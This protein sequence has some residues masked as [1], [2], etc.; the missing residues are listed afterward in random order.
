MFLMFHLCFVF[1]V[2]YV[3]HNHRSLNFGAQFIRTSCCISSAQLRCLFLNQEPNMLK[4]L[5]PRRFHSTIFSLSSGF[6]KCGVAVIRVSGPSTKQVLH[7]MTS[8][9]GDPKPRF[10][11]Y[12][13]IHK[14]RDRMQ[15]LDKGLVL[16]FPGESQIIYVY[17][18]VKC[19]SSFSAPQLHRRGL[20]RV[21]SARRI[22]GHQIRPH[23]IEFRAGLSAS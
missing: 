11:Y 1:T 6:G 19:L 20:L 14:P 22:S 5:Q 4:F 12:K 2:C 16:W 9:E 23:R 21:P 13:N 3:S 18:F 15:I 17:V 8:I 10:A 7:Q